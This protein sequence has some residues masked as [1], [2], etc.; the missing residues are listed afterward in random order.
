MALLAQPSKPTWADHL[1][2]IRTAAQGVS[3][4]PS[5]ASPLDLSL[6]GSKVMCLSRVVF[7]LPRNR[8]S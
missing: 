1:A 7:R 8:M 5:G 2:E 4:T 3:A 6:Q